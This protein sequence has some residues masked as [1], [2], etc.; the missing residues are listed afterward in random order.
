LGLLRDPAQFKVFTAK[1]AE[2]AKPISLLHHKGIV[3]L[4]DGEK[5]GGEDINIFRAGIGMYL[6]A[7]RIPATFLTVDR[8]YGQLVQV[9]KTCRGLDTSEKHLRQMGIP[10]DQVGGE[11]GKVHI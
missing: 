5:T 7:G 1:H 8:F 3:G 11:S 2:D 4:G 9:E 10:L 6:S